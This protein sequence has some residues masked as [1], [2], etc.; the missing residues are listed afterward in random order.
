M[1]E[2]RGLRIKFVVSNM[3]MVSLVIGLAFLLV[4]GLMK[5]RVEQNQQ[6]LLGEAASIENYREVLWQDQRTRL[7]VF[8]LKSEAKRS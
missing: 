4:G 1:K 2:L 7:P 8:I 6:R 3:V 5:F